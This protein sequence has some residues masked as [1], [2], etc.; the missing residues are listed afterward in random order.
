MRI[1]ICSETAT[2]M[3][4]ITLFICITLVLSHG[5]YQV[6]QTK[7]AHAAQERSNDE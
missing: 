2:T 3:I 1:E 5:C 6:E 4:V 7:R